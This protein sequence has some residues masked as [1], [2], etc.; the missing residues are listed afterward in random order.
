MVK[1]ES[2]ALALWRD[3]GELLLALD[4]TTTSLIS[5]TR[6]AIRNSLTG[7][8]TPPSCRG[9]VPDHQ[10][11]RDTAPAAESAVHVPRGRS[12]DVSAHL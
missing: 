5:S 6:G 1:A 9:A 4:S 3:A 2:G 8:P 7:T 12:K 11:G 10:L